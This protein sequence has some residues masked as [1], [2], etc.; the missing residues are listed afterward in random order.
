MVRLLAALKNAEIARASYQ[1][2]M[3]C[4]GVDWMVLHY[5]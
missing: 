3:T 2:S 5:H 4:G 1:E